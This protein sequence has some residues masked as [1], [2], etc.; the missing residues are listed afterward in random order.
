MCNPDPTGSGAGG[1]GAMP[2]IGGGAQQLGGFGMG[3]SQ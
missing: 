1:F 3:A 2:N